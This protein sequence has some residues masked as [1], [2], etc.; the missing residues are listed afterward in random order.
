[1]KGEILSIETSKKIAELERQ[2][3][4][5]L[6]IVDKMDDRNSLKLQLIKKEIKKIYGVDNDREQN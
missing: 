1:M 4:E 2:K 5:I 6:E 3:Q